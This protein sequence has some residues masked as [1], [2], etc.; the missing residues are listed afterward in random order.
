MARP[1]GVTAPQL[2]CEAK[3]LAK[4]HSTTSRGVDDRSAGK[5]MPLSVR[6]A[7]VLWLPLAGAFWPDSIACMQAIEN[8]FGIVSVTHKFLLKPHCDAGQACRSDLE[9]RFW[10]N[11]QVHQRLQETSLNKV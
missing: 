4:A 6:G 1:E 11:M 5:P 10:A 7:A 8:E 3:Q 2:K 9:E